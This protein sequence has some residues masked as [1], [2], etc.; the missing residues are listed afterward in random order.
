MTPFQTQKLKDK[1]AGI[2]R[3]LASEKKKFGCY[4]DS[5]GLRYL[6]VGYFVQMGDYAGGLAYL[7]WFDKNFPDDGGFP[8]FLFE[9]SILLFKSGRRKEAGK[10]AFQTYCS[11]P[12]WIDRFFGRPLTPLDIWHPSNL[13]TVEYTQALA[14]SV[15][16][17][18]LADFSEWLK[19][20]LVT[21]DFTRRCAKYVDIFRQLKT[22]TDKERRRLLVQEASQLTEY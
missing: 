9:S 14:Y 19:G 1:I 2:K 16:Q 20:L 22:E 8:E 13:T 18:E 15:K 17:P 10:K 5:R 3:T 12:Y 6:P 21:E 4:D 11:N 7:K